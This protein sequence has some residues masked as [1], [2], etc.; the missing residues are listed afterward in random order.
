MSTFTELVKHQS[1]GTEATDARQWTLLHAAVNAKSINIMRLLLQLGADPHALSLPTTVYI[2]KDLRGLSLTPGDIAR[3][4]G[5]AVLRAYVD[6]LA[7]NG[8]EVHVVDNGNEEDTYDI[9][10]P[11]VE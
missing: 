10:W 9:F 1:G 3:I 6:A 4:R 5:P 8:H 11:A 2:P 7:A